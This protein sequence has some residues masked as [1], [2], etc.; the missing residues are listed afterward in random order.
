MLDKIYYNKQVFLVLGLKSAL[1]L[2][3]RTPTRGVLGWTGLEC[4]AG[5]SYKLKLH[6]PNLVEITKSITPEKEINKDRLVG[7]IDGEGCFY[8]SLVK[9]ITGYKAGFI[10]HNTQH[11]RDKILRVREKK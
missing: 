1:V 10:S 11:S 6:F 8:L 5:V 4:G 2:A 7:F 9:N 3:P